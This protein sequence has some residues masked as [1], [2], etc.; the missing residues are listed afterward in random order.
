[1]MTGHADVESAVQALRL[2]V[3]DYLTKP[4]DI[5]RLK[6]LLADVAVAALPSGAGRRSRRWIAAEPHATDGL[7]LLLGSSPVMRTL[8]DMLERVAPTDADGVSDRRERHRQ[9]GRRP[10][11]CTT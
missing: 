7:G 5:G 10:D 9:G 8:Y 4:L 6:E 11:R 1:M 2:G 3:S